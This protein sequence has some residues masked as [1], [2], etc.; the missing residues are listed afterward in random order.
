MMIAEEG[1]GDG[2]NSNVTD[3]L[4]R[5]FGHMAKF[6]YHPK[7][8]SSSWVSSIIDSY[9]QLSEF[10]PSDKNAYERDFKLMDKAY[11]KSIKTVACAK[12][13]G[14]KEDQFPESRPVSWTFKNVTNSSFILQFL[15]Q[16]ANDRMMNKVEEMIND[17]MW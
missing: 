8:Q 4:V 12:S 14:Y 5:M 9:N 2:S 11:S 3:L 17:K 15:F 10:Q 6:Q 1:K 7:D 13:T 16:N